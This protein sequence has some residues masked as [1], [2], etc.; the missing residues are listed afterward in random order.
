MSK[1]TLGVGLL[2]AAVMLTGVLGIGS[3]AASPQ[4]QTS[5]VTLTP[6]DISGKERS[7]GASYVTSI[8]VAGVTC[9]KGEN[10][11][12]AYHA[13]RKDKGGAVCGSPGLGFKCKEGKRAK[14]PDVQYSATMKCR[15]GSKRVKSSYT[16]NI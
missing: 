2:S 10:V 13:C 9:T 4:A 14:V 7:L 6:C 12:R 15:K 5:G 11:V 8:K 1:K 3:G 16:Q